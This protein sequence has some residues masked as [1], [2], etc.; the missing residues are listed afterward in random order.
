MARPYRPIPTLT[1]A[2]IARFWAKVNKDGPAPTHRPELGPCWL[3]MSGKS[4]QGYGLLCTGHRGRVRFLA[5][6]V[7]WFLANEQLPPNIEVCHHCDTPACV[8]IDHLWLGTQAENMA[9]MKEKGRG[10]LRGRFTDKTIDALPPDVR[11]EIHRLYFSGVGF[12]RI[13]IQFGISPNVAKI[14]VWRE[15]GFRWPLG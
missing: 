13:G 12:K 8:R 2:Q 7:A 4:A 15:E 10:R 6:R 5:H 1:E 3:W 14:T 9:D 11:R